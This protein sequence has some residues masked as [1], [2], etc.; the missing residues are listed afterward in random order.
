MPIYAPDRVRQHF[1]TGLPQHT[2]A[3]IKKTTRC[4]FC[5]NSHHKFEYIIRG[6]KIK[7]G[8]ITLLHSIMFV[9]LRLDIVSLLH[10]QVQLPLTRGV[11]DRVLTGSFQTS[12]RQISPVLS[13]MAKQYDPI[14]NNCRENRQRNFEPTLSALISRSQLHS[15]R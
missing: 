1:Q 4:V 15:S 14:F 5:V 11:H 3:A 13:K 8:K 10:F 7:L 2:T 9:P 12:C 6:V